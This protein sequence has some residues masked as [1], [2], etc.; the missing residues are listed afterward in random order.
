MPE[1][2]GGTSD[3]RNYKMSVGENGTYWV[4][5]YYKDGKGVLRSVVKSLVIDNV[6]TQADVTVKGVDRD[7]HSKVIYTDT[8]TGLTLMVGIA[9]DL[10]GTTILN[11]T[12]DGVTKEAGTSAEV[13]I[14]GKLTASRMTVVGSGTQTINVDARSIE[15]LFEYDTSGMIT[16]AFDVNSIDPVSPG[17]P[18]NRYYFP[19]ESYDNVAANYGPLPS[20]TRDGY[21]LAGWTAVA[22]NE[23]TTVTDS[24]IIS[25]TPG[26]RIT[27]YA[28]WKLAI[29]EIDLS[30]G[31]TSLHG[32]VADKWIDYYVYDAATKV[33][34][35]KKGTKYVVR[36]SG[37]VNAAAAIVIRA[38]V[39]TEITFD[40]TA[41]DIS[42]NGNIVLE[43]GA[44]VDMILKG[45]TLIEGSIVA[46]EGTRLTID[47]A[48][49]SG[50]L[51][52][53]ATDRYSAGIGGTYG[54]NAGTITI[55]GGDV[56]VS[57]GKYGAG[58]G[59]GYGG[60]GGSVTINGDSDVTVYGGDF[61][62]GIGGGYGGRH[63][64]PAVTA[65]D[66]NPLSRSG[67]H[68]ELIGA[69][70]GV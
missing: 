52:V 31:D 56:T 13:M 38:N 16:V 7:D 70:Y 54:Q 50:A 9:Y 61:G 55:N 59:G 3:E 28:L 43:N 18:A 57:G 11:S 46:P 67:T 10:D 44:V 68:G 17:T 15:V 53:T 40:G 2:P 20:L 47:S 69:G 62:A 14:S 5:V 32:A 58:I 22:D 48:S 39:V 64:N 4:K 23:M 51:T 41:R 8:L 65:A 27:L 30:N 49:T 34:T 33:L 6:F 29:F 1:L 12:S 45:L 37:P 24:N 36:Q 35:I 19:N 60:N 26:S 66:L 25:A 42:L 63:D 21:I